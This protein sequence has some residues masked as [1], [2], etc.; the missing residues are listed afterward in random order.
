MDRDVKIYRIVGFMLIS[1]DK[2][3]QWV[4]FVKEVRAIKIEHALE[5]LYS[6]LGSRHK[7]KRHNIKIVNVE[8]ITSEQAKDKYVKDLETLQYVV[9]E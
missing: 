8:E 7:V 1:Q 2:L 6:E 4:K 9:I 5:K 3:P